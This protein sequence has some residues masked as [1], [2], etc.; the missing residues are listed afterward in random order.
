[1][2]P[3]DIR[4]ETERL[5]LRLPRIEDF[6]RYAQ[7]L[8]DEETARYIGGSLPRAAAWRRF[9]QMPGAWMVQ[10]F[11]MFSIEDRATGRYLG[12]LGPWRPDGW[13][14][15]ELG[16]TFHRDAWGNGYATEAAL[17]VR[18]WFAAPRAISLI[19]PANRRS[20]RV[21]EKLG[22][23]RTDEVAIIGGV[24]CEVWLHPAES[25]PSG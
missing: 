11:A 10:G 14:G 21:A 25:R 23:T 22:C 5:V 15:N 4:I 9:L 16:W 8:G 1:M 3:T 24:A 12:Q 2:D 18:S 7:M 17:A 19:E 20:I 6:D 13:P